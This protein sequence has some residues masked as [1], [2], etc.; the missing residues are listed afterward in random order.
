VYSTTIAE[1]TITDSRGRRETRLLPFVITDLKKYL[2]YL[3][4]L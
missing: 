1:T 2:M 3:S 4:L